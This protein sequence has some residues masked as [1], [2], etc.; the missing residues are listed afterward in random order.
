MSGAPLIFIYQEGFSQISLPP[1][2]ENQ[3]NFDVINIK[4]CD[5]GC[6]ITTDCDLEV[7]YN[8]VKQFLGREVVNVYCDSNTVTKGCILIECKLTKG[9]YGEDCILIWTDSKNCEVVM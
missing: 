4:S 2:Q 5:D 3:F 7:A 6:L 8:K 1:I 9:N